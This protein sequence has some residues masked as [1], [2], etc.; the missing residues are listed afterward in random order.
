MEQSNHPLTNV[1]SYLPSPADLLLAVPRL[2]FKAGA[3]GEH[4]DSVFGKL[5]SGGSIIATPTNLTNATVATTAASFVQESVTAAAGAILSE[6]D[7]MGL[8]QTL[9]NVGSFFGYITSK[10]AIATFAIVSLHYSYQSMETDYC[11][12]NTL[13]PHAL[14]CL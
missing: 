7:D 8:F 3:L 10:W 4:I 5:R 6:K 13:K 12:G 11:A 1:S 9:K 14:L 2:L